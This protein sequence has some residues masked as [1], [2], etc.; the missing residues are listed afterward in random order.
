[1]PQLTNVTPDIHF[2]IQVPC[3]ATE[4]TSPNRHSPSTGSEKIDRRYDSRLPRG[5][6][7][8][9]LQTANC[10]INPL[11]HIPRYIADV[12]ITQFTRRATRDYSHSAHDRM[13]HYD[14][15]SS[16]SFKFL[17]D[18]RETGSCS[19][20]PFFGGRWSEEEVVVVVM[21]DNAM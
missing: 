8:D 14:K 19:A 16:F 11:T 5:S 6:Q 4:H 9:M 17:G 10:A 7:M 20:F 13:L 15:W 12:P 18:V 21:I 2:P 3:Q 1:M